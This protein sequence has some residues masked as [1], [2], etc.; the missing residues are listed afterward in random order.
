MSGTN[1]TVFVPVR[2]CRQVYQWWEVPEGLQYV[3]GLLATSVNDIEWSL[4]LKNRILQSMQSSKHK[5]I[6]QP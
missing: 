5:Y 6:I 3:G 4:P 1:I 2:F